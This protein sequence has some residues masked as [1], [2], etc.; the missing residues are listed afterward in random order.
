MGLSEVMDAAVVRRW[1]TNYS[2]RINAV[3]CIVSGVPKLESPWI[4]RAIGLRSMN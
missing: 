3:E 4:I 2:F 1:F